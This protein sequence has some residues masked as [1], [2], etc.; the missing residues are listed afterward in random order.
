MEL[1]TRWSS[2]PIGGY[3]GRPGAELLTRWGPQCRKVDT[4]R[5]GTNQQ[6]PCLQGEFHLPDRRPHDDFEEALTKLAEAEV[7]AEA[8]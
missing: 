2:V 5:R 1:P 4:A 6:V 8:A 3:I 7:N